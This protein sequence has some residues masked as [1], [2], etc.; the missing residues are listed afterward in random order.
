MDP[1]TLTDEHGEIRMSGIYTY[2]ETAH[3]F[4]ER[5]NYKGDFMPGYQKWESVYNP[6]EVGLLYVCLLYTSRCV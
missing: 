2:G 6:E 4:V 1:I 3:V 5:K